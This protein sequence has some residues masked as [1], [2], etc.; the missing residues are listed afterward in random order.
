MGYSSNYHFLLTSQ[1]AVAMHQVFLGR[2]V[3]DWS[4][5]EQDY[6]ASLLKHPPYL[7]SSL[8]VLGVSTIIWH[9]VHYT[10]IAHSKDLHGLDD[11]THEQALVAC[12]SLETEDLYTRH[13]GIVPC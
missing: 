12:Y 6:L 4:H 5:L 13:N 1:L 8:W 11:S 3:S 9:C 7:T 10:W 2:M